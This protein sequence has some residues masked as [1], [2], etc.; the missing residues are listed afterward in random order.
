MSKFREFITENGVLVLGGRSDKNN[1]DLVAQVGSK[2]VVL[3][4]KAPGSPFVNLKHEKPAQKDIK[5]AA[6]FCAKYSQDWRDNKRDIIVHRFKGADVYKRKG[7]KT[8]TFGVK[9]AKE[10]KV[11]KQDIEK[12]EKCQNTEKSN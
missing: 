5:Q 9:G 6:V 12:F 4:T 2:E 1:E 8:G 7:M 10:I 3:H 11:K